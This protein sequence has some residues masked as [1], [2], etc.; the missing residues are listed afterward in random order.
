MCFTL[1][2]LFSHSLLELCIR[3]PQNIVN[4]V[5]NC[6]EISRKH[7]KSRFI[8]K[9]DTQEY[10]RALTSI[11][12]LYDYIY[13]TIKP[14]YNYVGNDVAES[15]KYTKTKDQFKL[16]KIKMLLPP[17]R[18]L[19][20]RGGIVLCHE[21]LKYVSDILFARPMQ[22]WCVAFWVECIKNGNGISKMCFSR[23]CPRSCG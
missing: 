9:A 11:Y 12:F 15:R 5:T 19:T 1:T 16:K 18:Y 8:I 14:R 13:S 3:I 22:L 7:Q 6:K 21:D 2:S 17:S 10:E 23:N 20:W 4:Q